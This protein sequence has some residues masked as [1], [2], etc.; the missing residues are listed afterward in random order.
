MFELVKQIK[1]GVIMNI[2]LIGEFNVGKSYLVIVVFKELNKKSLEE[3]VKLVFFVNSD[4]F[5]WCIKSFF[6]DDFE[7]FMEFKVIELFI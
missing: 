7:K 6:K 5:M 4:V 2:F 1:V 3:Y